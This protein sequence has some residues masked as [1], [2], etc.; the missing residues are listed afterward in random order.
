MRRVGVLVALMVAASACSSDPPS[1]FGDSA[2]FASNDD[3]CASAVLLNEVD[4]PQVLDKSLDCL[5]TEYDAGRP[6]TVDVDL[7]TVEGDSIYHRYH[8]DGESVLIVIDSRADEF[9][10]GSV[11]A[12]QCASIERTS[13]LPEGADCELVDHPGFPEAE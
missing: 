4:D 9:G 1:E 8:Y 12:T 5:F 6:V 7:P 10:Q 2:P 13:R 11:R 3:Q